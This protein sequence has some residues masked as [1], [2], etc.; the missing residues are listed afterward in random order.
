M[1]PIDSNLAVIFKQK[2][3]ADILALAYY[4]FSKYL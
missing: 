2:N 1:C 4:V 3:G